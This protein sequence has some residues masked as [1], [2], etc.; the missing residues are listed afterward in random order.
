MKII[1][2][3]FMSATLMA[4]WTA[5]AGSAASPVKRQPS[6]VSHE[7][8]CIQNI[9]VPDDANGNGLFLC[10]HNNTV[11]KMLC[12][13]NGEGGNYQVGTL[14]TSAP[15]QLQFSASENHGNQ[16]QVICSPA[17]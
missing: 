12:G 9:D 4:S 15:N 1:S 10:F 7:G 13:Q 6:S 8:F 11:V 17:K 3:W 14:S 5:A 2:V 16:G